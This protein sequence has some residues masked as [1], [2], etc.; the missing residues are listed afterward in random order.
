MKTWLA[1]LLLC[2][3]VFSQEQ[4]LAPENIDPTFLSSIRK[5]LACDCGCGMTVQDC[6]GGMICSES[7]SYSNEVIDLLNAGKNREQVLQAMVAKYGEKI[8][9]A[10]TKEGF[11]LTAWTFPFIALIL[12][13][14]IVW[15]VVAKWKTQSPIIASA[16]P[17]TPKP[18]DTFYDK[19]FEEE[20]KK[21]SN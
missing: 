9:S 16:G 12:G 19:R 4:K 14:V 2:A 18:E 21:F 15:R 13:G 11:N 7:R 20:F 10:P 5:E 17:A 1:L 8:L 6:L 3:S